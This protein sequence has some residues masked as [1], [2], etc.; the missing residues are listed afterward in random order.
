MSSRIVP[1]QETALGFAV[2]VML[3]ATLV[4]ALLMPALMHLLGSWNWWAPPVLRRLHRRIGL[5]A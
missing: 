5:V 4:R 3:D 2:A 1:V